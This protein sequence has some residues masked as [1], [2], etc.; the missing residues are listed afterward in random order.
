MPKLPVASKFLSN[1]YFKDVVKEMKRVGIK[2]LGN[3]L[4]GFYVS[5]RDMNMLQVIFLDSRIA[6]I[7]SDRLSKYGTEV[8]DEFLKANTH[9]Y[10]IILDRR[11]YEKLSKAEQDIITTQYQE[12][13]VLVELIGLVAIFKGDIVL[14]G[15]EI[16]VPETDRIKRLAGCTSTTDI[17]TTSQMSKSMYALHLE[18][19]VGRFLGMVDVYGEHQQTRLGVVNQHVSNSVGDQRS[20][21]GAD[22]PDRNSVGDQR[23]RLGVVDQYVS[24]RAGDQE[25]RIGADQPASNSAGNQRTRLG[26]DQQPARN[27]V[28][29]QRTRLSV[30]VQPASNSVGV[31]QP[32]EG[33]VDQLTRHSVVYKRSSRSVVYQRSRAG[34]V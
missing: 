22:Q 32:R 24:N 14:I 26:A 11:Q 7:V 3:K 10:S 23:T 27:N 8:R 25:S 19:A 18:P 1:M 28:G 29:D 31:H 16:K 2:M 17:I 20:R 15:I 9:P 13:A 4:K 5:S 6:L 34:I 21:L 33:V 30:V 12:E